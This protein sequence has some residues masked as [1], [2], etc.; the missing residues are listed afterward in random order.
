MG[1]G[2]EIWLAITRAGDISFLLNVVPGFYF[3]GGGSC[4]RAS[5][6]SDLAWRLESAFWGRGVNEPLA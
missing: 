5:M 1:N 4:H 6:L 3:W 2:D